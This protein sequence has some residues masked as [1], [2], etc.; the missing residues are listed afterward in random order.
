MAPIMF[1]FRILFCDSLK[2]IEDENT[3][4]S[5]FEH[6]GKVDFLNVSR[7]IFK[8]YYHE[9]DQPLPIYFPQ[10][11]YD[12]SQ[13]SNQEKWRKLFLGSSRDDFTYNKESQTL[14][15][16]ITTLDENASRYGDDKPSRIYKDALSP[17]VI[18]GTADGI[19][20]ELNAPLFFLTGLGL[21]IRLNISQC[22]K[23]F[24]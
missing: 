10:H 22:G 12:D 11:R 9:M 18:V 2:K 1:Y 6:G 8:D 19:D 13:E 21:I 17:K 16:K 5:V 7:N 14:L 23:D 24:F 15:F 4:W 20:I 3:K